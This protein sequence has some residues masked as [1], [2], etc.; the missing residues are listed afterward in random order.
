MR[1]STEGDQIYLLRCA[2]ARVPP[3]STAG[4]APCIQVDRIGGGEEG[5]G[6]GGALPTK[7]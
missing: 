3:N 1:V 5:G 7:H 6:G 4:W 2:A